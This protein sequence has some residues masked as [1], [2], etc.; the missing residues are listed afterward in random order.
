MN[1]KFLK[2]LSL[3]RFAAIIIIVY[4]ALLSLDGL[5]SIA[6]GYYVSYSFIK[7]FFAELID[8]HYWRIYLFGTNFLIVST[9]IAG[10]V[11]GVAIWKKREWGRRLWLG[12]I[13][14]QMIMCLIML[15]GVFQS[16]RPSFVTVSVWCIGALSWLVFS[17][18][19][20][21]DV[22]NYNKKS[23]FV[24]ILLI[25]LI[26][27]LFVIIWLIKERPQNFA[28][29][30]EALTQ[31]SEETVEE[32]FEQA[33]INAAKN[34]LL[35]E[36]YKELQKLYDLHEAKDVDG[37]IKEGE[38]LIKKGHRNDR[39]VLLDLAEAYYAKGDKL[40][41]VEL[42]EAAKD[43]EY[44]C[45]ITKVSERFLPNDEAFIHFKLY[46]IYKELGMQSKSEHEY[47]QAVGILKD[48]HKEKFSEKIVSGFEHASIDGLNYFNRD[49]GD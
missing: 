2:R 20:I 37:V 16:L 8:I 4:S 25:L 17:R 32:K 19:R 43:G 5:M 13:S 12:L 38:R 11:A 14:W 36:C 29:N 28:Q 31:M 9:G 7:Y 21:R 48:F 23:A 40:K 24:P 3:Y 27:N 39:F 26:S 41:V 42:L 44:L 33:M 22:F 1:F 30:L 45:E 35:G 6:F 18:R 10:I 47:Q 34:E 46:L 15:V 49:N